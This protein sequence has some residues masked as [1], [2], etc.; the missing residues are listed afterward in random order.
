MTVMYDLLI[1]GAHIHDGS[2]AA[3][4]VGDVG[5]KAGRIAC[6]GSVRGASASTR[7]D[8]DGLALA[9]GFIDLHSHADLTLPAFPEAPNSIQQGVTTEV[10]GNCGFSAAPVVTEHAS[11]LES[12]V[13]GLGPNLAWTWVTFG[14]YLDALDRSRPI[15]NVVPLVGHGTLRVAAMGFD[16][17]RPTAKELDVMRGLL[18]QSLVEGAW[19]L[20][21][22]LDYPP[23][24]FS[25]P[26]EFVGLGEVLAAAEAGY[27]THLRSGV[28]TLEEALAEMLA[29][30]TAGVR[31]HVSHINSSAAVWHGVPLALDILDRARSR[32]LT[33]NADAYPYTAGA[34][35]LSQL[36][37]SWACA[38]GTE[39]L[40]SR[41]ASPEERARIK[42]AMQDGRSAPISG[43]SFDDVLLTSLQSER[44]RPWEGKPLAE[45]ARASREDPYEFLFNLLLAERGNPTMI[46]FMMS[47]ED[48]RQALTW[49]GTAIGS[50]QVGVVSDTAHVHPRAY[51]TFVRVLGHYVREASLFSLPEAV[52]RMT[53]LPADILGLRDRGYIREGLAADLVVFDPN[54][55]TDRSTYAQPTLRPGGIEWVVVS[56]AVAVKNG[57]VTGVRAGQTLRARSG[58]HHRVPGAQ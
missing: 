34:T 35:Y 17:R 20:S 51:G 41:L 23:G 56:G 33:V 21:S 52:R 9:P 40:L 43:V 39:A 3:P 1:R 38:G 46:V 24:V 42:A 25:E 32:G 31:L 14:E 11:D 13:A 47:E 45:A 5:I 22:G 48:V 18:R 28:A 8:G 16:A 50:D 26:D 53:G 12:L 10:G 58:G 7:I 27:H 49:S 37:P 2:G 55:V 57:R 6:V 44:Y 29:V 19:G 30:G 4:F 54:R 36:L 15:V